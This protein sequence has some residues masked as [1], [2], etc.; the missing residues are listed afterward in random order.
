MRRKGEGGKSPFP[1]KGKS[2]KTWY[3]VSDG[4]FVKGY[5]ETLKEAQEHVEL[6]ATLGKS[7]TIE[8]YHEKI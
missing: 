5:Y 6:M 1:G 4:Y 8:V 3:I 7:Y 2:M